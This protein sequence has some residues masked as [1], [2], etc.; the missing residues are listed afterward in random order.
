M[1][2]LLLCWMMLFVGAAMTQST[3]WAE[4]PVAVSQ[5]PNILFILVDDLGKEW[6][7][8]YG[9]EGIDT[10][11]ID[12]LADEGMKFN[13]AWCMPQC[14]PTRVTL[15]TGQYPFRHGW[16]NHW[17][18][19]RWG[20]GCHFDA[21]QH[22]TFA[23]VLRE[24]GYTT[25]AAGK[26]QIDDFR[27]EPNAM[28]EAGF[29]DW[30][31]W[32]GYET[33]NPPSG[34]RY[35]DPYINT[36]GQGSRTHQG[37]FGPDIYCDYLIKFI[38]EHKSQPMLLYYP[39][40]LTHSPLTTTPDTKDET[41]KRQ[42]FVGMVQYTDE[43]VG[44]LMATLEEEG[45][46]ENTIV[47][48]TTDNG[49]GRASWTRNQRLGRMVRGGKA[50]KDEQ[51]GVAQPL[52]VSCPGRIAQGATTDA[53][54]D[55]TDMLP[56]FAE[57]AGGTLPAERK[58]DGASFAGLLLGDE[59]YQPREWILSMG[60]GPA[61]LRQGR[62][63][64]ELSYDER[65]VRNDRYKLW[66]DANH[67]PEQLYDLQQ[68]PWEEAN[69]IDSSAPPVLAA[70]RALMQVVESLPEQDASPKYQKNPPQPWDKK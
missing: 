19:P 62:V 29:D 22:T 66:V 12:R 52:I 15:L 43:L 25:C 56:T 10:K 64:P 42:Q 37:Q 63:H 35:W 49:T 1:R 21:P 30:C 23:K 51:T 69:L 34:N 38:R 9:G 58:V 26:W 11:H 55:F 13:N 44:R 59:D 5:K 50:R 20:A 36:R 65:V 14:T 28:D 60:G 54:V 3:S 68:D 39:M 17:D 61:V 27:V 70:K 31:M 33:G 40:A 41:G 4:T 16:T 48:F 45:I 47:F 24:A 57:L 18:V 6:I 7:H 2:F 53:L 32:T 46:R 8:C 67:Q